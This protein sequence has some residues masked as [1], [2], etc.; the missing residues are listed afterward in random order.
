MSLHAQ[1]I[2]VFYLCTLLVLCISIFLLFKGY[3][4]TTELIQNPPFTVILAILMALSMDS[5]NAT[6]DVDRVVDQATL[7]VVESASGKN[8]FLRAIL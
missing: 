3:E 1:I 7:H 8:F 4:G 5:A 2:L 6:S